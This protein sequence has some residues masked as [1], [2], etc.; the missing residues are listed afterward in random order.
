MGW[1]ILTH[2][3]IKGGVM[4]KQCE[5]CSIKAAM[6]ELHIANVELKKNSDRKKSVIVKLTKQIGRLKRRV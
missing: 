6:E 4:G 2:P 1:R 3:T 5:G